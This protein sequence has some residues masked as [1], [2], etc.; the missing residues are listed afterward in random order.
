LKTQNKVVDK[1]E[2]KNKPP[3]LYFIFLQ[4]NFSMPSKTTQKPVAL[5]P[6]LF[7]IRLYQH[8]IQIIF[9]PFFSISENLSSVFGLHTE[10]PATAVSSP[11]PE[12]R[13]KL[14][15][16]RV[17]HNGPFLSRKLL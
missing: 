3:N 6:I 15:Y 8:I 13:E 2:N 9:F 7:L 1:D 16:E 14:K 5:L 11:I 17:T 12:K 10:S 4:H